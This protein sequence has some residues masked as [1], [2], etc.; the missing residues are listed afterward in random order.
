VPLK[1]VKLARW[2]AS[3]VM[4]WN[5]RALVAEGAGRSGTLQHAVLSNLHLSQLFRVNSLAR[6]LHSSAHP[7]FLIQLIGKSGKSGKVSADIYRSIFSI[8]I[9]TLGVN[10]SRTCRT[11]RPPASLRLTGR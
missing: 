11:S 5:G 7:P 1:G 10:T 8:L 3:T 9:L 2:E 6:H 4:A